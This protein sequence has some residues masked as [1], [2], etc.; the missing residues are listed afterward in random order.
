MTRAEHDRI[1]LEQRIATTVEDAWLFISEPGWFINEGH[2]VEHEITWPNDETAIVIDADH[3]E[4]TFR[5]EYS[6]RPE[7]I[8]LRRLDTENTGGSRTVEFEVVAH[9]DE[10]VVR[11]VESGFAAMDAPPEK[12][13][14]QF[15][16]NTK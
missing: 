2:L 5:V 13:L 8:V 9:R 16:Q 14:A 11:L 3:G 10:V 1:E 6:R 12:Q 15:E 7:R 4:F